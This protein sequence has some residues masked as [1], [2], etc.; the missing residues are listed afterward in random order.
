[1]I[2]REANS[3]MQSVADDTWWW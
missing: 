3:L 2:M 1:M